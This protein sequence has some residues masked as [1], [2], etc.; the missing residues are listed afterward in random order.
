MSSKN[1]AYV[2]SL[3]LCDICDH[4]DGPIYAQY[5][6]RL[7]IG[8]WADVC[9]KHFKAYGVGLGTGKGQ[10]LIVATKEANK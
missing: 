7:T 3:P 5:D 6:A 9:E 2:S 4:T 10:R 8:S 1:E